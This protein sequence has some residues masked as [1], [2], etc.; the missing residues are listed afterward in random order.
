MFYAFFNE[1]TTKNSIVNL[2]FI[3]DLHFCYYFAL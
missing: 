3:Y 2:K 1:S